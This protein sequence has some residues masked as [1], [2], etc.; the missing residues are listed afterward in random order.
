MVAF[1]ILKRQSELT[2]DGWTYEQAVSELQPEK[3][4]RIQEKAGVDIDSFRPWNS[5]PL[6]QKDKFPSVLRVWLDGVA[7]Q[8]TL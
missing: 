5:P 2:V 7:H 6:I 8:L 3:G 4:V 1:N